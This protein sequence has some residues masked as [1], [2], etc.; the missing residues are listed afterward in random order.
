LE[1]F[2]TE[3]V[4]KNLAPKTREK[5]RQQAACLD[6][7]LLAMP[8][9]EI[10]GGH[11]RSLILTSRRAQVHSAVTPA[12]EH[13]TFE[14]QHFHQSAPIPQFEAWPGIRREGRSVDKPDLVDLSNVRERQGPSKTISL[15]S[16]RQN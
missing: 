13:A 2:F 3:H 6:A 16:D 4:D 5:Y 11:S 7:G 14:Y 9:D 15:L 12:L 10:K 1:K 8:V